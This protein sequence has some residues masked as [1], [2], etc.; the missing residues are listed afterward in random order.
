MA[1]LEKIAGAEDRTQVNAVYVALGRALQ[2]EME[3]LN[4][5]GKQEQAA[6]VR[7]SV[8][9]FLE[10]LINNEVKQFNTLAW[11][12][13][14]YF[15]LAEGSAD[16]PAAA[17]E[18]YD[19]AQA[20][21]QQILDR[22]KNDADFA[23]ARN[24][25]AVKA[26]M[27]ACR[28]RSGDWEGAL[29]MA[30]DVLRDNENVL[31]IQIEAARIYKD[32]GLS[33]EPDA[34]KKLKLAIDGTT[35]DDVKLWGWAQLGRE[36]QRQVSRRGGEK[37]RD[38]LYDVWYEAAYCRQRY[39]EAL[40]KSAERKKELNEAARTLRMFVA[41]GGRMP[42]PV[43]ERFNGLYEE[44][45]RDAG[46]AVSPLPR[47]VAPPPPTKTEAAKT[48][49]GKVENGPPDGKKP[50]AGAPEKKGP[51]LG[52]VIGLVVVLGGAAVGGVF[53]MGKRDSK[54]RVTYEHLS[55][56]EELP[57]FAS[58]GG[59]RKER[60]KTRPSPQQR[61]SS[62]QRQKRPRPGG[63]SGGGSK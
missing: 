5:A 54:R 15:G 30:L 1:T 41:V 49:G 28:R 4:R 60:R 63:E 57:A 40:S 45:L 7:E 59:E 24:L 6:G 2:K 58:A 29:E 20:A 38:R 26:K 18:L 9:A 62:P 27:A 36:I 12:G 32:W 13:E 55:V 22:A 33:G 50:T 19:S 43:W 8:E 52:L 35:L 56:P 44:I 21:F 10:N 23:D 25:L 53:L 37:Y 47:P 16:D 42:E 34:Y 11:V 31:S 3:Q 51:N 46:A 48:A 61:R 39:A 14:T 17:Q